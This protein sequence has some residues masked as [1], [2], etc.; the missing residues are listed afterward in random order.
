MTDEKVAEEVAEQEF[1]RFLAEMDLVIDEKGMDA[2]DLASFK[3]AKGKVVRAMQ[4][5]SLVIDEKGQPIFTPVAGNAET[6]TFYEPTGATLMEADRAKRNHDIDKMMKVLGST[7]KKGA[8]VFAE[9]SMRDL[10]VC[11]AIMMLFLASG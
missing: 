1:E 2:E 7:T 3:D 4:R 5:G 11:Q 6:I 9:M 10:K 8:R